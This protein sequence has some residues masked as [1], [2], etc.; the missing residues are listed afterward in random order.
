VPSSAPIFRHAV[1]GRAALLMRA[2]LAVHVLAALVLGVFAWQHPLGNWDIIPYAAVIRG[3]AG[4]SPSQVSQQ[5]YADVRSYV[6]DETFLPMIQGGDQDAQYRATLYRDPQALEEN[7]RFYSVKPLY[8]FLARGAAA[9]TGNAASA[10]VFVSSAAFTLLLALFP[11]AFGRKAIA[12]AAAWLLVLVGAPPLWLIATC[13]TPDTLALLFTCIAAW[14][15]G[16][17]KRPLF[18]AAAAAL[19]VLARPDAAFLLCPLLLGFAWLQR[20]DGR[21]WPLAASCAGLFALFVFLGTQALPWPALFRH[22]FFG[23]QAHPAAAAL[24]APLTTGEYLSVVSRTLPHVVTVRTMLFFVA[25]LAT[26]ALSLRARS[27]WPI[28][29]LATASLANVLLHYL[30]FPIDEYGF[31]RTFLAS[32]FVLVG[33]MLLAWGVRG[34]RAA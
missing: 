6:G 25:S 9:W 22:T 7:L 2:L 31:E 4:A 34:R 17:A 18:I 3:H 5:A 11:F 28:A 26:I 27:R 13:A 1:P 24:S 20:E 10:A 8:I 23:R 14:L 12:V 33:A 30:A 15:A 32:Y 21:F 16:S 19:A 29:L